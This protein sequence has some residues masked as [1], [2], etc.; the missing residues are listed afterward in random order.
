MKKAYQGYRQEGNERKATELGSELKVSEQLISSA[1]S[2]N[3][4]I[5]PGRRNRWLQRIN[6][7]KNKKSF[8]VIYISSFVFAS[9]VTSFLFCWIFSFS[10]QGIS[11]MGISLNCIV[12]F[13]WGIATCSTLWH[14][15][16]YSFSSPFISLACK[17][18]RV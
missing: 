15:R 9:E 8:V 5:L 18:M 7:M 1:S 3:F 12:L 2:N 10:L 16:R 6:G 13:A 4:P 11:F 14:S 17:M